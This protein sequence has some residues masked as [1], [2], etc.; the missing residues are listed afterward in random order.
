M[1]QLTYPEFLARL[2]DHHF[3]RGFLIHYVQ[4]G[5]RIESINHPAEIANLE[6]EKVITL[7]RDVLPNYFLRE[8]P[9]PSPYY[10]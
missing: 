1:M 6:N 9:S 5:F 7:S 4:V 2:G 8:A 10:Q 3:A